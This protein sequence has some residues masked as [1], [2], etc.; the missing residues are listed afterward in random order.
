MEEKLLKELLLRPGVPNNK[1]LLESYIE[2]SVEDFKEMINYENNE[3]L[4]EGC[5]TAVKEL[6]LIKIN[7]EGTEGIVSESQSSGG[8]TTYSETL[9]FVV[10]RAVRKHRRFRR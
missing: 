10:R 3:A 5:K 8:S 2:D 9:P 1:E 4:P 6:V 7:R